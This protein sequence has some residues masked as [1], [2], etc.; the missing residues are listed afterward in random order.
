MKN[1]LK[2]TR[3]K[4]HEKTFSFAFL[5]WIDVYEFWLKWHYW[6]G[7]FF[8]YLF[9]KQAWWGVYAPRGLDH[10]FLLSCDSFALVAGLIEASKSYLLCIQRRKTKTLR[11]CTF[12]DIQSDFIN[13][14][15]YSPYFQT[16]TSKTWSWIR[17]GNVLC[18]MSTSWPFFCFKN[19]KFIEFFLST[20]VPFY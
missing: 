19:I 15:L 12:E 10:V 7:K 14:G 9:C 3:T 11:L 16:S 2:N 18:K 5:I 20:N 8:L 17:V 6:E 1:Y 4:L 13:H